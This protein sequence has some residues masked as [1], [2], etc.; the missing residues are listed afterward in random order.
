[1]ARRFWFVVALS[2]I[3]G[4]EKAVLGELL[5]EPQAIAEEADGQLLVVDS[6]ARALVRVDPVTGV[7]VVVSDD[8]TGGGPRLDVPVDVAIED[9]TSA[10][11]A[12]LG[13]RAILRVDLTTGDRSIVSSAQRGGGPRFGEPRNLAIEADGQIV[14]VDR[15]RAAILRVDP[16]SGNRLV[17]SDSATGTGPLVERPQ[18]LAVETMGRL[19]VGDRAPLDAMARVIRIDP[20]TG[21]RAIVSG[22]GR[23]DGEGAGLI[24]D[25]GV[26][27]D[28]QILALDDGAHKQ[29][30]LVDRVTGDRERLS[31]EG[32]GGGPGFEDPRGLSS[33][34]RGPLV[35]DAGLQAVVRV[36][37]LDSS[38]YVLGAPFT[39]SVRSLATTRVFCRNESTGQE[40][41]MQTA[42]T[43][44]DCGQL[45]LVAS[46]GDVVFTGAWGTVD[47]P[48][49]GPP[50]NSPEGVAVEADGRILVIDDLEDA[51][52]RVDPATGNR[53]ILSDDDTGTGATF[54]NPNG[55]AVEA[56]GSVVV[57]DYGIDAVVRVDAPTGDR[58]IVSDDDHGLG[59]TFFRPLG[60]EVDARGSLFVADNIIPGV[61][62]V[63]PASG[64]RT[65]F[66]GGEV[67]EGPEISEPYDIAIE[68]DGD[69][70]VTDEF[71][72]TLV[73]ADGATGDRSIVSDA[74][75][76]PRGVALDAQGQ[77]LVV[78]RDGQVYRVD[79]AT[80][81]VTVVSDETTGTGP[82]FA[83][84]SWIAVEKS[85]QILVTD[86]DNLYRVD[87]VTGDRLILSGEPDEL[88][89]GSI[90]GVEFPA[91]ARCQNL[92][93]GQSVRDPVD[94]GTSWFCEL[95]GL[96]VDDDDEVFTGARATR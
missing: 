56:N 24:V 61:F 35:A 53:T 22:E 42:E 44:W 27:A 13:R 17:V 33:S 26:L 37:P 19:L 67:G 88:V 30:L 73:R 45:G 11:V 9:D 90:G 29:L 63:D 18:G 58:T 69:L 76:A 14:V 23:G 34:A 38:R 3:G 49:G 82:L 66:S 51:V 46:P 95:H 93:T 87:P 50:F 31:G 86:L 54:D 72:G 78:D 92:T 85:G 20:L 94:A 59:P 48:G 60:I 8:G 83:E 21:D 52:F 65:V 6:T 39:A 12:D 55:V 16:F 32:I 96:D 74:F 75:F 5:Q 81:A 80:G 28:G 62:R 7:G 10:I 71:Q 84:P 40:V 91:E 68:A 15:K 57:T 89:G 47:Q 77:A 70:L 64:D 79:P 1:M 41:V 2:M 36:D 25:V 43:E 4:A